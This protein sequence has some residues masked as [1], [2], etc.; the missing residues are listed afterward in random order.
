MTKGEIWLYSCVCL[1]VSQQ[2]SPTPAKLDYELRFE[3]LF[4]LP[5]HTSFHP[6]RDNVVYT[7]QW[8]SDSN[9]IYACAL[10]VRVPFQRPVI[11]LM[12]LLWVGRIS[13]KG[14]EKVIRAF[15]I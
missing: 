11:D 13:N 7:P 1:S 14:R 15:F 4:V 9:S 12:A 5:F 10:S 3:F 6:L 2:M 8:V